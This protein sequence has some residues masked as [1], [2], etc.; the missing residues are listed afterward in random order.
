MRDKHGNEVQIGDEVRVLEIAPESISSF[1]DAE[2]SRIEAM[3][4][5]VF[6]IDDLP[7]EGKVSVSVSW[8]EGEGQIAVS[9]L[10]MLSHEFELVRKV[11]SKSSK[12]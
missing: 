8:E 10:Y 4:N 9:G 5:N 1:P 6:A 3:L 2:K 12:S 11:N 7:E